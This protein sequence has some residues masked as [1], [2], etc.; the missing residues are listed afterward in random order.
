MNGKG[1]ESVDGLRIEDEALHRHV[2]LQIN[3]RNLLRSTRILPPRGD[4]VSEPPFIDVLES[5]ISKTEPR[6]QSG[7]IWRMHQPFFILEQYPTLLVNV[8]RTSDNHENNVEHAR[9]IL[10]DEECLSSIDGWVD[11][12]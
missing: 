5:M 9:K 1:N 4:L 6:L 12:K 7:G 8:H 2:V 10:H 11:S 3:E